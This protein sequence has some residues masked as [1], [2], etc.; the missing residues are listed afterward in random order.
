MKL[1][2]NV[3]SKKIF[4]P[5]FSLSAIVDVEDVKTTLKFRGAEH[6]FSNILV[7]IEYRFCV[8]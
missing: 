4:D 1:G 3:V 8:N 2:T 5:Y 7:I 6:I